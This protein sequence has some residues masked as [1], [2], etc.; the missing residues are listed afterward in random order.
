MSKGFLDAVI[1]DA[2]QQ[3]EN[4]CIKEV[5]SAGDIEHNLHLALEVHVPSCCAVTQVANSVFI[6]R[7]AKNLER[8]FHFRYTIECLI[9]FCFQTGKTRSCMSWTIPLSPPYTH[10]HLQTTLQ[11]QLTRPLNLAHGR[12]VSSGVHEHHSVTS[13]NWNSIMKMMLVHSF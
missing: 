8:Q 1:G 5:V 12:K 13:H 11:C 10:L 3:V 4:R 2:R 9:L 6:F 7:I